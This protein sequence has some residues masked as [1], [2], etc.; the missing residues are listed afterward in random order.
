MLCS[1]M[2]GTDMAQ[3]QQQYAQE[4][5]FNNNLSDVPPVLHNWRW[6]VHTIGG[7]MEEC[8]VHPVQHHA[9]V[10]IAAE[11]SHGLQAARLLGMLRNG[12]RDRFVM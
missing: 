2:A 6:H 7:R 1:Y 9:K 10:Q 5:R 8:A 12:S 3:Q 11:A 4:R